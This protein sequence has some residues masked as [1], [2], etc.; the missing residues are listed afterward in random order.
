MYKVPLRDFV[1]DFK[2][3]GCGKLKR[4]TRRRV[5]FV[6]ALLVR[7]HPART[8]NVKKNLLKAPLK[9]FRFLFP[10]ISDLYEDI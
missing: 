9:S 3:R 5:F 2:S 7:I 8:K 6:P 10:S 4:R 1:V